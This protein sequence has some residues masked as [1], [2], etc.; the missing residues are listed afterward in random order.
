[1]IGVFVCPSR[2]LTCTET[3]GQARRHISQAETC[4]TECWELV[5]TSEQNGLGIETQCYK[6]K[7][8]KPPGRHSWFKQWFIFGGW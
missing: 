7:I 2:T 3:Q 1:M 5:R 6:S 4:S 8:T